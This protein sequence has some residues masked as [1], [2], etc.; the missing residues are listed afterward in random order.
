MPAGLLAS[1]FAALEPPEKAIVV[2]ISGS[3][4]EIVREIL[5]HPAF[6]NP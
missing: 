1:Q 5:A 4:E 2:E 6:E 3:N